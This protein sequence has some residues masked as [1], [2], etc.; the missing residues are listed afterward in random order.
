MSWPVVG[1]SYMI[2]RV[3]AELSVQM[4]FTV[5]CQPRQ[6]HTPAVMQYLHRVT[7]F[8]KKLAVLIYMVAGQPSRAP[9]L[10]SIQHSNIE[11]NRQQNIYIEDRMVTLVTAY[12]KGFYA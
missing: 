2:Q 5:C 4:Q 1:Q 7:R 6:L 9:E 12:H 8:K 10:L 3:Q 11:T